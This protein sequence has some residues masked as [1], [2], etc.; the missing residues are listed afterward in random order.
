MKN[1]TK[2]L[3]GV[4]WWLSAGTALGFYRDK[5]FI[6]NDTDIDIAIEG[7][8]DNDQRSYFAELFKDH[9]LIREAIWDGH[10]MQMA[11]QDTNNCIFD[12]YFYYPDGKNRINHNEMGTMTKPRY[13]I[14]KLKTKYGSYPFPDPIED[15]L[16]IRYGKD[17][18]I[19]QQ[20]KGLYGNDF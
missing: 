2:R 7:D 15:Y 6:P 17:W 4:K 12:F 9:R 3:K 1:I 16:L 20:K 13:G 14:K 19:P 10:I 18:K 8:W 11:Y 5:D